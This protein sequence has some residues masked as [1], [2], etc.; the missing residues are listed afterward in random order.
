MKD[1]MKVYSLP[2][3]HRGADRQRGGD[4]SAR[5]DPG[6]RKDKV[7]EPKFYSNC[8]AYQVSGCEPQPIQLISV[9]VM[10]GHSTRIV[11]PLALGWRK[12]GAEETTW[13]FHYTSF[14]NYR[15]I[16]DTGLLPGRDCQHLDGNRR[17]RPEIYLSGQFRG[18]GGKLQKLPEYKTTGEVV[19]ST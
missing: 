10:Q 15:R 4:A 13:G 1:Y 19:M 18:F 17:G 6:A 12:L 7:E 11:N 8:V 9:R 16:R 14:N 2:D 5:G 3:V